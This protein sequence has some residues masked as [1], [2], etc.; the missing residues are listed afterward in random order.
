MPDNGSSQDN[1]FLGDDPD[2]RISST[3]LLNAD[4]L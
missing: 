3:T 1:D 2:P 4:H